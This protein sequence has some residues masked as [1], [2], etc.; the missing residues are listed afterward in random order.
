M[1]HRPLAGTQSLS[2]LSNFPLQ[3]F[4]GKKPRLLLSYEKHLVV[5]PSLSPFWNHHPPPT[6][7]YHIPSAPWPCLLACPVDGRSALLLL[8]AP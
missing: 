1:F 3:H 4:T 7:E 5:A 8:S 2:T 6:Q